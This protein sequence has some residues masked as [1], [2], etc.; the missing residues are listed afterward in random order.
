MQF[1]WA[2]HAC[3]CDTAII[4]G[5]RK[6]VLYIHNSRQQMVNDSR[7][8]RAL[9]SRRILI[10][11]PNC[12]KLRRASPSLEKDSCTQTEYSVLT[13]AKRSKWFAAP[14]ETHEFHVHT[15]EH[16]SRI[17]QVEAN[18]HKSPNRHR[19]FFLFDPIQTI[20]MKVLFA[21]TTSERLEQTQLTSPTDSQQRKEAAQ[22]R[23]G[24]PIKRVEAV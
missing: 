17:P 21:P 22:Q 3:K 5:I 9:F 12:R 20:C 1:C 4:V 16:R 14:V 13:P 24:S 8:F 15:A 10:L 11:V 19:G 18:A 7:P 2:M 23:R 6:G